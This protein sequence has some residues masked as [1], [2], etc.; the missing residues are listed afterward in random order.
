MSPN[1][2]K[3]FKNT[4]VEQMRD[5][6]THTDGLLEYYQP[7]VEYPDDN[8][9]ESMIEV[10]TAI[11][12]LDADVNS[13]F[14][15]ALKV[16]EYLKD[17]DKTQ[18]SDKRLWTYLSH[19]TFR[20]YSVGR[21]GISVPS[22]RLAVD[23]DAQKKALNNILEHWFISGNDRSLRRHS[24]GRLW[25]AAYLTVAPWE[26]EPE[27]YAG[28]EEEDRFVYTRI[29]FSTQDIYQ[30]VLERGLGRS[31]HILIALL[32]YM[33]D[34]PD[35][36][37]RDNVR[38]LMKELNLVSGYRKLTSLAFDELTGVISTIAGD[39]VNE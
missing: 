22:E 20:E 31:N 30:Q 8:M 25:W 10:P 14:D 29:L 13:D 39:L 7:Y 38:R 21:W 35:F 4:A 11:P 37:T 26:R 34:N 6:L 12:E 15:N 16:Y 2:Q 1:R 23:R 33:K 19:V 32:K 27:Y 24:I 28:I 3:I 17:I 9:F 18:A 5:R 36:V